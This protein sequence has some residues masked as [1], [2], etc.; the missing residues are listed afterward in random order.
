MSRRAPSTGF[1]V[2]GS[3]NNGAASP[4][5]QLAAF[6][7]NRRGRPLALQ[8]RRRRRSW[9]IRRGI[10]GRSRSPASAP[11]SPATTTCRS[12]ARS[13]ARCRFPRVLRNGPNRHR[14]LS[15]DL[16]SQRQH[17]AGADADRA[18]ARRRFLADARR[19][20]AAGPDRRP[21]N[22]HAVRRQ[23]HSRA[24]AS[25]RR[26]RRCLRYYPLP[27]LDAAG[28]YNYQT[29]LVTAVRQDSIQTAADA[30]RLRPQPAVRHVRR[31]SERRP[32]RPTCSAFADSTATSGVDTSVNWSR[33]FSQFVS[34][35][36]RYQFTRL[37]DARRRR[38]S[39]IAPT[40][41]ATPASPAT[42]RIRR[43]GVRRR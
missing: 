20:R 3:V 11:R 35:R 40:C 14:Q 39:R 43:T 22:R 30:A 38:T 15:A 9:A 28:G 29:P 19:V 31:I 12:R 1:L 24:I 37:D 25:A 42:I 33:R 6:G 21:G 41:R 34:L 27:N 26:P 16:G 17:R 23:R 2:N 7:N 18:R 13:A 32:T 10:R 36:L 8:L 4:F 5:A